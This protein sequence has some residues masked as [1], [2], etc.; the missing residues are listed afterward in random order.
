MIRLRTLGTWPEI[1]RQTLRSRHI[2]WVSRWSTGVLNYQHCDDSIQQ[3]TAC[4]L[5]EWHID[6]NHYRDVIMGAMTSQIISHLECLFSRLFRRRSEKTSKVRA[7]GLVR[8]IHRWLVNSPHK[9]PVTRKMFLF[10]DVI[11]TS[12]A[13]FNISGRP[14]QWDGF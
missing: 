3:Q 6:F 13:G 10:D 14:G 9:W 4:P 12:G 5:W 7:T 8:E 1:A 11:M 2:I